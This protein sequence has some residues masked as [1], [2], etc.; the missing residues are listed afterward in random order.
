MHVGRSRHAGHRFAPALDEQRLVAKGNPGEDS[1]EVAL[2]HRL[3]NDCADFCLGVTDRDAGSDR[4]DLTV[5]AG[6]RRGCRLA[7]AGSIDRQARHA[8]KAREHNAEP[9]RRSFI[10]HGR[11]VLPQSPRYQGSR[12]ITRGT[13]QK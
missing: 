6:S 3:A 9:H 11:L 4:G 2:R 5:R 1:L 8:D 13:R 12:A 7:R 10:P